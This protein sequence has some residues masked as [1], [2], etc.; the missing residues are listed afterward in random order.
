MCTVVGT[1]SR[2]LDADRETR[3]PPAGAGLESARLHIPELLGGNE[4]APHFNKLRLELEGVAVPVTDIVAVPEEPLYDAVMV[5]CWTVGT[6]AAAIAGKLTLEALA[7]T[8]TD[9]GT[10][11]RLLVLKTLTTSPG[12]GAA[13]EIVT[14]QVLLAPGARDKAPHCTAEIVAGVTDN[15]LPPVW[16]RGPLVPVIVSG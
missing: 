9:A 12:A 3:A 16:A 7:G 8:V 11:R 1:L 6:T 2:E 5:A 4:P 13:F 15:V 10:V 14:V